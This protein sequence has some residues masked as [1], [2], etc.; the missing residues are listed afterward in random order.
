MMRKQ[1]RHPLAAWTGRRSSCGPIDRAPTPVGL[2][3]RCPRG[4]ADQPGSHRSLVP[5]VVLTGPDV[6][7]VNLG[8]G[9]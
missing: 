2:C 6:P 9:W 8:A 7:G 4:W 1:L 5:P 3:C